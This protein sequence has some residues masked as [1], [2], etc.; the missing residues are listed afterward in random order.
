MNLE[1]F[2][3][4]FEEYSNTKF[5]ENQFSWSRFVACRINTDGLTRR[6]WWSPFEIMQ[7]RLKSVIL[8]SACNYTYLQN[9]T[10]LRLHCLIKLLHCSVHCCNKGFRITF[11][12]LHC[13]QYSATS[14]KCLKKLQYAHSQVTNCGPNRILLLLLFVDENWYDHFT[15]WKVTNDLQSAHSKTLNEMTVV[16]LIKTPAPF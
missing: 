9:F 7:T 6:N 13:K 11:G 4:I 15:G 14:T 8:S 16:L 10:K 5:Y 1:I 3:Q 2:R 12:K